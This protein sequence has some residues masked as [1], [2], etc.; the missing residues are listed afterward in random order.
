VTGEG[1]ETWWAASVVKMSKVAGIQSTLS[2]LFRSQRF[3]VLAT[4][5]RGQPFTSL[6][7][8]HLFQARRLA[9]KEPLMQFDLLIMGGAVFALLLVGLALTVAEFR[10]MK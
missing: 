10:M 5:D 2:A 3:A 9:G 1:A 8:R 6:R 7:L 4:D